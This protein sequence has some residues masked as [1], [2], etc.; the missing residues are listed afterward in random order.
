MHTKNKA[1]PIPSVAINCTKEAIEL[2]ALTED[3]HYFPL[4]GELY[5]KHRL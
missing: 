1:K 3:K 4:L 2:R 5:E